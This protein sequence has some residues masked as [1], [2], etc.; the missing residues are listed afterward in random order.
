MPQSR[1]II[2]PLLK[3]HKASTDGTTGNVD[4]DLDVPEFTNLLP[5]AESLTLLSLTE[6][7]PGTDFEWN[8]GFLSGFDRTHQGNF[9]AI[10]PSNINTNGSAR[11]SVYNTIANFNLD[12]R[13]QLRVKGA[14][15]GVKSA[16]VSAVLLVQTVGM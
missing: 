16:T 14:T 5:Y 12:S 2:I 9:T 1:I 7:A 6:G 3:R 4:Y 15:S 11:S 8:I 10:S 13:L